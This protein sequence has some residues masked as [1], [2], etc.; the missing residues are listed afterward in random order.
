MSSH[1]IPQRHYH[2]TVVSYGQHLITG[3]P[4]A[5][6]GSLPLELSQSSFQELLHKHSLEEEDP[7]IS[8]P[9]PKPHPAQKLAKKVQSPPHL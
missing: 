5:S 3:A 4:S 2:P 9:L 6:A 1:S 7:F 8:T